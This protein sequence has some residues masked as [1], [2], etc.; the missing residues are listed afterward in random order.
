M[1]NKRKSG[2]KEMTKAEHKQWTSIHS[3][4]LTSDSFIDTLIIRDC[5]M[6]GYIQ[7]NPFKIWHPFYLHWFSKRLSKV[8]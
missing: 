2:N 3:K 6:G 5:Y 4:Y 8:L 1:I 7:G